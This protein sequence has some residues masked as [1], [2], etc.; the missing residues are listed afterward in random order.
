ME[1]EKKRWTRTDRL[2]ARLL[3]VT[4]TLVAP[5]AAANAGAAGGPVYHEDRVMAFSHN[6]YTFECRGGEWTNLVVRGDGDTDLD[7]FVYDSN[8]TLVAS[9]TDLSD[10]CSARWFSATTQ[11]YTVVVKNYGS[12]YNDF[13]IFSD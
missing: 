6:S 4:G 5:A 2:W 13:V 12:V 8:G 1:L 10:V 11:A 9:H 3:L 7:L